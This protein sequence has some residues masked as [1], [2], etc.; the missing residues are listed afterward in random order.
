MSDAVVLVCR[1]CKE[2]YEIRHFN[3]SVTY[4]CTR[5]SL[6][7]PVD[8][9]TPDSVRRSLEDP[10]RQFGKF[11]LVSELGRGGMGVV[12]KAWD[13]ELARY[14]ALKVLPG[15]VS[16]ETLLRFKREAQTGSKL[17]HP[18]IAAIYEYGTARGQRYI[19]MQYIDGTT[20]DKLRISDEGEICRI[21]HQA[22]LAIA[23]A[24]RQGIV[25]RDLKPQNLMLDRAGRVFVL[26]FGLAKEIEEKFS[27]ELSATGSVLGTPSYMSPEQAVGKSRDLDVRTDVYSL[28][29]TL[30]YVA[31]GKP[32]FE[33][34]APL[35]VLNKVC[36]EPPTLPRKVNPQISYKL[37]GVILKAMAKRREDR[38][39]TM[40]EFATDLMRITEASFRGRMPGEPRPGGMDA[41]AAAEALFGAIAVQQGFASQPQVEECL[42]LH[43]QPPAGTRKALGQILMERGILTEAQVNAIHRI[44]AH[45]E[46]KGME[47]R[48][49]R[50]L[51]ERGMLTEAQLEEAVTQQRRSLR[52]GDRSA[53]LEE[54]LVQKGLLTAPQVRALLQSIDPVEAAFPRA[55]E[56]PVKECPQCLES[57]PQF[58]TSCS[59]CGFDIVSLKERPKCRACRASLQKGQEF[60]LECGADSATGAPAN[61]DRVWRCPSCSKYEAVDRA[62]CRSCGAS[63]WRSHTTQMFRVVRHAGR[64]VW[65][66]A[67]AGLGLTVAALLVGLNFSTIADWFGRLAQ[68]EAYEVRRD[69]DRFLRAIM[70]DDYAGASRLF[71]PEA[72]ACCRSTHDVL[73]TLLHA[74]EGGYRLAGYQIAVVTVREST[75]TVVLEITYMK[76]GSSEVRQATLI[77][78]KADGW[79]IGRGT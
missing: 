12:Y 17:L 68:G 36:N 31:T 38:Y 44:I 37:E 58:A 13:R 39:Q 6:P 79:R 70:S 15:V 5:C 53:G 52:A 25:H 45:R 20:L 22:A 27:M 49:S 72:A 9:R 21:F 4:R 41:P 19:A 42:K 10:D 30:Y 28:G 43:A 67:L 14:A 50:L 2:R 77:W 35:E 75:A 33:G 26:D 24:H 66:I 51:L 56:G 71:S 64:R 18:N 62:S 55:S 11:V 46:R 69:C 65:R 63:F 23:H 8:V 16:E 59:W 74:P 3:A 57:I 40:E 1:A 48:L 7:L 47:R 29:A 78:K 61:P 60:C 34:E 73:R 76:G 54:I 32:P